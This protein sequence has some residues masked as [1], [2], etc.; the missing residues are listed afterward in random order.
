MLQKVLKKIRERKEEID[1]ELGEV[2][3]PCR[4]C[5]HGGQWILAEYIV[6]KG[7]KREAVEQARISSQRGRPQ[8]LKHKDLD[9]RYNGLFKGDSVPFLHSGG[10]VR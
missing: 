5:M 9:K 1:K 6:L 3:Y 4:V 7:L 8:A 2:H 10:M